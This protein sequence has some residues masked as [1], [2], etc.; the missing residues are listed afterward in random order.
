MLTE[1]EIMRL[2]ELLGRLETIVTRLEESSHS[3]P[4]QEFR[5]LKEEWDEF[6]TTAFSFLRIGKIFVYAGS[7]L[8]G[9]SSLAVAGMEIYKML[10]G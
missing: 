9:F 10:K 5:N 8:V 2:G 6:K 4:C 1:G 3:V 7:A